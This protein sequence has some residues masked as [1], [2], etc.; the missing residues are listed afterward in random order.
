MEAYTNSLIHETSPYLL[1]HAN[2]PVNWESWSPAV[3]ERAK[4]ENKLVLI[5]VGYSACHWCH[6]ME[7]EC[8]EDEEVAT[9]MNKFFINVKVDREERPDVD[10]LYMTAVQLMTNKGGWPLNCFTLPDGRPVYGGTYFPKEQWMHVLRSLEHTYRNDPEKVAEYA[11]E[12]MEGVRSSELIVEASSVEEFE[13]SKLDELVLRWKKSF[14]MRDGGPTRAPKFPLPCNLDFLLDFAL[15]SNDEGVLKYVLL[16]LDKMALGGIYDQAG[17]GFARYSVDMLWKIPHFEKMLYDNGQLLYIYSRAYAVT[18]SSLYKRIVQQT[19]SWLE[20]EMMDESGAFI[21]AIDADSE[22]IEGKYY[23][24]TEQELLQLDKESNG[25][26]SEYYN[27]GDRAYWEDSYYV[28]LRTSSDEEICKRL[29][30]SAEE[31]ERRIEQLNDL[32]LSKRNERI[33]PGKDDKCLTSWNAMTLKGLCEAARVFGDDSFRKLAIRNYRWLTTSMISENGSVKRNYKN[34]AVKI[35]GFLEDYAA[36]IDAL[37]AYYYLEGDGESLKYAKNVSAYCI[38][39]FYDANSGMFFFTPSNTDLITRKMEIND[40][41]IPSGNSVMARNLFQM[42]V[43]FHKEEYHTMS[44]KM[45]ANVYDGMETY[46]SGYANWALLLN[47][48][49][50]DVYS[51][52]CTG[53]NGKSSAHEL[54]K[55][56]LP[57]SIQVYQKGDELPEIFNQHTLGVH[58]IYVCTRGMCL[59]PTTEVTEAVHLVLN[60]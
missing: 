32:I 39:E 29:R 7:H 55:A 38:S 35:N 42:S 34:G 31:F 10:Q 28:L 18:K 23:I 53:D 57:F 56:P 58:Q 24:W 40:N 52:V 33:F 20:R 45:L 41:V 36:V 49:V 30:I 14:D 27:T 4:N 16:T 22:G 21:S 37:L 2:N 12:L 25:F 43:L 19:V 48:F 54:N 3:F 26:L 15:H 11:Q 13:R 1:Q 8:F 6:V 47:H 51:F 5:S 46:G 44:H 17:G 59:K 50:F 60:K 9:L